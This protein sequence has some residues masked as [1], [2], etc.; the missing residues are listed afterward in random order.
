MRSTSPAL[1]AAAGLTVLPA[2]L[3]ARAASAEPRQPNIIY[4]IA[5]D[6]GYGEVGCYGQEWIRTPS[7]DRIAA[8]GIRFTQHYSAFPVSAPARC[9]LMTGKHPGHS[10]IRDN[11]NPPGRWHNADAG[12]F[13]GQ[14]PIPDETVTI[15]E[16]LKGQ[17]YATGAMGKWGLGFEGSQGAPT[18]QGFDLF[19]GYYCQIHA[20]NHYPRFLWRND[21]QVPLEG[22]TRELTGAQHS[23]GLFVEEAKQFIRAHEDE[24]F[25]LFMPLIIPHL[26]I[27]VP[28]EY[29][30]AYLD[31]IPEEEHTHRGYLKHP[32][33]RA[34]YAG[35]VTYMDEG[36]G[37]V[38]D[39]VDELGLTEDTLIIFTSDN[40]PTYNRLG[41][42]D[43]D[44]FNSSGPLRGRK[45]DMYEGGIR[46]PMV[47]RWPGHIEPDTD[48]DHISALWDVLPTL[49]EVSGAEIPADTD[50]L[51][52]LPALTGKKQAAH[53]FL[54]W[55]FP[56]YGG[57]QAVRLGDYKALRRDCFKNPNAPI[58]LYDLSK[59]IG[60]TTDIAADHPEIVKEAWR[61]IKREHVDSELFPFPEPQ[62]K[63]SAG[64]AKGPIISKDTWKLVRVS[65]ES[66]FNGKTGD[67][68]F[69]GDAGTWWHSEW[70][71]RKADH[72]HEIVIDLSATHEITG[73]RY[74]PRQDGGING[75][76][77]EYEFFVS[78]DASDLGAPVSAGSF[79]GKTTE[80]EVRFEKVEGRY[81]CLRSLSAV[82]GQPFAAAAEI[83]LLG[84]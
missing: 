70:R 79:N 13:P 82:G 68:A 39:L 37:E 4:I 55:E 83:T 2:P 43:S 76:I 15:A 46:V 60:E 27:Q 58:Q 6:L 54:Y 36:I 63:S 23:Q 78:S 61:V 42:S 64:M 48:S 69:D 67:K 80:Q 75:T 12:M 25:F 74:L 24:P 65:S 57:Q 35:M 31:V 73:L 28:Q 56:S 21:E 34:A 5:D 8:Q 18:N 50:G 44:F 45:G 51:S 81:I 11:G 84:K 33:P 7:I 40:G 53:E 22:N 30:D 32:T 47:A 38:V 14:L 1:L 3:L 29:V 9:S 59:D 17:G 62:P 16:I 20:H 66:A 77:V 19:F 49:C 26:S 10:Y 41:G 72:P 52:F 71:D